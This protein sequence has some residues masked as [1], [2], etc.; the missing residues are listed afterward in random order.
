[1]EGQNGLNVMDQE[2]FGLSSESELAE[3]QKALDTGYAITGQTGG[4]ALRVQSLESSLKV[5]TFTQDHA[6]LWKKIA[7]NPAYST[8]EEYSQ[9]SAYGGDSNSFLPA[10][11][12][13][14]EDDST[15]ARQVS[16]VKF[17]G[18]TRKVN[19][20][21][22][23]VQNIGGDVLARENTNG[24][25]KLIKDVEDY[26]FWGDSTLGYNITTT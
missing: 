19:H 24:I 12:L 13:P 2:G 18:T 10:G 11:T 6:K 1:M 17:L 20:P 5:L 25:T 9:L 15:Y 4:A 21:A 14:E 3:L 26:L 7:K 16:Y 22:T 23:L 8:V